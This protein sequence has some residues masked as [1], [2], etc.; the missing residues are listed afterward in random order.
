MRFQEVPLALLCVNPD[1][2][3]HG[4]RA[5]EQSA[6]D[7]LFANHEAYMLRL[8]EDI[9]AQRGILD[10]P[11]VM[12]DGSQFIVFD[13]NRRV[14]ALKSLA[15]LVVVPTRLQQRIASLRSTYEPP[16]NLLVYCQVEVDRKVLDATI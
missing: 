11:L 5:S 8:M 7:W 12:P 16:G 3:R 10:P 9:V 14:T 4:P 13:G 6:V 2:D 15:G 1:N